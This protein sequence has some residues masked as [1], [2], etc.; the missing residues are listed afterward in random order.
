MRRAPRRLMKPKWIDAQGPT[1]WLCLCPVGDRIVYL[2]QGGRSARLRRA[3]PHKIE[4]C[5]RLISAFMI[6]VPHTPCMS[7][8]PTSF[9]IS[10]ELRMLF[11]FSM[12]IVVLALILQSQPS[13]AHDPRD[14][15][16]NCEDKC[17]I[18]FKQCDHRQRSQSDTGTTRVC[19]PQ[20]IECLRRC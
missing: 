7:P 9:Y 3:D 17:R 14:E 8:E 5:R 4:N 15:H 6:L 2:V 19:I 11:R 1:R 13:S 12:L 16:S 10:M 18:E 20:Q